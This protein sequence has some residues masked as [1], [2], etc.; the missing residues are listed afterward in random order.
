MIL[1]GFTDPI[2]SPEY[3]LH[4]SRRRVESISNYLQTQFKIAKDRLMTL[5]YGDLA[6]VMSSDT[7]EQRRQ[8]GY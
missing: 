5:W 8:A 4:L 2:G 3:N 1:A 6:P 7:E